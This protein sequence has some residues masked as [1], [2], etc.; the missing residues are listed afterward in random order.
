MTT[1][2]YNM[3]FTTGGL[4]LSESIKLAEIYLELNDWDIV[5][6]KVLSNNLLQSRTLS[7]AKRN[8][9][10]VASRLK[11]LTADELLFFANTN[12]HD[13]GYILWIAVCRRYIFI[14]EFAAEVLRERYISLKSDLN[15]DEFDYFFHRKSELNPELDH[16]SSKTRTK[17]RQ[18]LFKILRE[19]DLLTANNIIHAALL[20]PGLLD[21]ISHSHNQD[22]LYFP[23]FES[24]LRGMSQ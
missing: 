11:Y 9:R 20:S 2:K 3:S 16:I 4:F 18:V 23:V 1:E 5:R 8:F 12:L 22:A 13:Q 14:S 7:T 10:E 6:E 19:S 15:Y 17:L 24:D 21:L